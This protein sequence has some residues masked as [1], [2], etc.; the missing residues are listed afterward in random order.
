LDRPATLESRLGYRFRNAAL[1]YQ[2]LTHRSY[3]SPHNERLEFLGDGV[4]DCVIAEAL[5]RRFPSLSEGELTRLRAHLVRE[6]ALGALARGLD[7]GDHL[8]LGE[9]ELVS[10]GG[11]R[12]SILADAM[13]A[14]FG[15]IHLDGGYDAA[16]MAVLNVYA[17]TLTGLDP[18]RTAKDPK[19]RLQEY[20]QAGHRPLP[21]YRVTGT[22][23]AAHLQTFEV[24]CIVADLGLRATGSGTSRQRAEQQAA[25]ALLRALQQ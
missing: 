23:G 5:Y 6:E 16:R 10:A 7:L 13:E 15:A 9:G 25:E 17:G 1:L 14:V 4:L 3:G 21:E 19:T 24:E 12:P 8:R 2:A 18:A 20:L 11:P 22:R